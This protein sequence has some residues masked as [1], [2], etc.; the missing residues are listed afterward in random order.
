MASTSIGLGSPGQQ[1]FRQTAERLQD[2][3][4][5]PGAAD[6]LHCCLELASGNGRM[7]QAA[8]AL[9]LRPPFL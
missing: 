6:A 5:D 8:E 1:R 4:L 7:L 9:G 2:P 3:A